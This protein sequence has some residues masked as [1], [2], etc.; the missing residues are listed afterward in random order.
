MFWRID[1]EC[2]IVNANGKP[3]NITIL[4]FK[5]FKFCKTN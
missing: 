3:E 2:P 4:F 1:E 5:W